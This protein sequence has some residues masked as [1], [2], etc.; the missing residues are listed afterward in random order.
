MQRA[1]AAREEWMIA[2]RTKSYQVVANGTSGRLE[3]KGGV[4]PVLSRTYPRQCSWQPAA[5]KCGFRSR[6]S[7]PDAGQQHR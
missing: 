5:G 7:D 2:V 1:T 6:C 4:F 3:Q